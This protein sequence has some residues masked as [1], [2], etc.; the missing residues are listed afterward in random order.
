MINQYG[1]STAVSGASNPVSAPSTLHNSFDSATQRLAALVQQS[2]KIAERL[3]RGQNGEAS[4]PGKPPSVEPNLTDK[5]DGFHAL[6]TAL[7]INMGFI[8]GN[9]G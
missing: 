8:G 4:G 5:I 6:L 2:G 3:N 9:I 7:E 1:S